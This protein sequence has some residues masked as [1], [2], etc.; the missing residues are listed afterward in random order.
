VPGILCTPLLT[1][2]PTSS[3]PTRAEAKSRWCRLQGQGRAELAVH[4]AMSI[5]VGSGLPPAGPGGPLSTAAD[6]YRRP[7]RGTVPYRQGNVER[8]QRVAATVGPAVSP[9]RWFDQTYT[10]TVDSLGRLD[11]GQILDI[12]GVG[13]MT[14]ADWVTTR[15]MSVAAHGLDVAI[16]LDRPPWTTRLT[17]SQTTPVLL[18]LLSLPL[19]AQPRWD[20]QTLLAAGTGRRALTEDERGIL[21]PAQHRFP[22]LS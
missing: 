15:V 21:G 11:P 3:R 19:P 6:Y 16:T 10:A 9:A 7:E 18:S 20:D 4:I 5:E 14:L 2:L 1:G 22:L 8:T 17:L 12:A 13:P